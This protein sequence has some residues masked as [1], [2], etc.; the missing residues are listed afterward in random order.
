VRRI[1]KKSKK[2]RASM[3]EDNKKLVIFSVE[4]RRIPL[5]TIPLHYSSK[6]QKQKQQHMFSIEAQNSRAGRGIVSRTIL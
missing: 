2:R 4:E 1:K 5:C 6:S 3:V